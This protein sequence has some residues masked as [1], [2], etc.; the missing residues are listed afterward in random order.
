MKWFL[1]CGN[2]ILFKFKASLL[3]FF[4]WASVLFRECGGCVNVPAGV[5]AC[6]SAFEATRFYNVSESSPL[7]R[8]LCDGPTCNEVESSTNQWTG[9]SC[10]TPSTI[11]TVHLPFK[12]TFSLLFMCS[13]QDSYRRTSATMSLAVW[14]SSSLNAALATG[15]VVM[16]GNQFVGQTGSSTK[17][18]VRWRCLPVETG[19]AS[20]RFRCPSVLRVRVPSLAKSLHSI[21]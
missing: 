4:L 7:A 17:T 16:M 12:S 13:L 1:F 20:S 2:G 11:R 5:C 21:L 8:E 6:L 3:L 18:C 19:R 10:I 15:T 14:R 9:E